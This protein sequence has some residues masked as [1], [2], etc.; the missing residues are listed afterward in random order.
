MGNDSLMNPLGNSIST[1]ELDDDAVT[2]IKI[3]DA[4]VT[5]AKLEATVG[6]IPIG[7]VTWQAGNITGCPAMPANFQLCNGAA[8]ANAL[9][10][11][12]G[13]NTPNYTGSNAFIRANTT[14]GATGGTSAHNHK[15][16]EQNTVADAAHPHIVVTSIT[17]T[18]ETATWGSDGA[19]PQTYTETRHLTDSYTNNSSHN[20]P[21]VD[22]I[23]YIRIY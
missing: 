3:R 7:C 17:S 6:T 13:Q 23:P 20:P 11:M 19:T 10:P 2:T 18:D 4:N 8:I 1:G 12:N 16:H 5:K 15:W 14:A 22:A 9:S 21:Y